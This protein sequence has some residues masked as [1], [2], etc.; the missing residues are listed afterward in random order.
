VNPQNVAP[1]LSANQISNQSGSSKPQS[2][3]TSKSGNENSIFRSSLPGRS[4]AGSRVSGLKT[5]ITTK[6]TGI[7][8]QFIPIGGHQHF[9]VASRVKAVQLIDELQHGTL[10]LIIA[11]STIVKSRP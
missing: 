10:D 1:S 6:P 4:N 9:D 5:E 8:L 7:E 3:Q 2:W 11:A